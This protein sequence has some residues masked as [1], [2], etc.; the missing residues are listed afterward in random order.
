MAT[1]T[2][3]FCADDRAAVELV[4]DRSELK[5]A[6]ACPKCGTRGSAHA[7]EWDAAMAWQA[8]PAPKPGS[9]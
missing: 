6:V 2:C 7:T 8:D 5:F 3:P 9:E 1:L 4:P